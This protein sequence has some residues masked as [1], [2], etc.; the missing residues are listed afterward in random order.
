MVRYVRRLSP[1]ASSCVCIVAFAS[2]CNRSVDCGS[3]G[4]QCG[5]E[6]TGGESDTEGGDDGGLPIQVN[7]DVDILFVI[8]N[9]GS[10]GEEQAILAANIGS[11][12][13]VLEADDVEADYRIG[14]TTSDMGNPWCPAEMTTPERGNLVMSSCKT[15]LG[16][17]VFSGDVDVQDL[18]C[19]DIC[20]LDE[21]ELTIL[22]TTTDVDPDPQPRP[23]LE[24]IAGKKN[25]P[26]TTNTPDAFACFGPQGINGCGFE[27]QLESMY[28]AVV[29][30]QNETEPNYGF[31]RDYATL[32]VVFLTD[33]V[34]CSY[35]PD[36]ASIFDEFGDQVFW[37]DPMAPVPSS[38]LCWNAGVQC[39]GD[40]SNYDSCD[41]VNKG[42]DGTLNVS[43]D[44]AVLYPVS[45]YINLLDDVEFAKQELDP[46]QEIIVAL[47]AGVDATGTPFYADAEDPDFQ[48]TFGIG[49]GCM[50]P[51]PL[52]PSE[53]I[54]AVPPVRLRDV[55]NA[56]TPGN[57]FS[58]CEQD[59]SPA[60]DAVADRIRTQIQPACF[61]YCVADSNPATE[62]V[63]AE[64]SVAEVPGG[65][66][67]ECMRDAN[68][69]VLDP[70][71]NDYMMPSPE[72]N[73]CYALRTDKAGLTA[74][75]LDDMDAYCIEA[76]HNLEF[77]LERRPGFPA[78]SGV[79]LTADCELA[80]A[81][82]LTC[83]GI[84]G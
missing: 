70:E 32:A 19:N 29:R 2:A 67:Q 17:F 66:V 48:D 62:I 30:S 12:I 82:E 45:R 22:P 8:D 36:W 14:I 46:E 20:T 64:C 25:I 78:A 1:I 79:T 16:D 13:N 43:D 53:P 50:A 54:Q 42:A 81:P 61:A 44:D 31:I 35:N 55:T 4:E 21:S 60:L 6:D 75:V 39:S 69:Y 47:I 26:S 37:S 51:N 28:F 74:D 57:M 80:N 34:D 56:F 18:A 9:S 76:N 65:P 38:A 49:P 84:G 83:P 15:R 73:V 7:K 3:L 11:F 24:R 41:P 10:M 59:Y 40:P 5:A 58:I 71:T 68:G 72:T 77:V 27:S 23:W 52:N 63:D 33:E